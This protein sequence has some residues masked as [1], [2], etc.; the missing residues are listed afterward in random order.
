[1]QQARGFRAPPSVCER[2]EWPE[3]DRGS[4]GLI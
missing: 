1:L 2:P 4:F 3:F